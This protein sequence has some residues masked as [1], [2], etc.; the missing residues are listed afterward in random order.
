VGAFVGK[1][2]TSLILVVILG[3]LSHYLLDMIPHKSMG[4]VKGFKE[5]GLKGSDK[6]DLLFKGIEPIMGL[7][8]ALYI[9]FGLNGDKALLMF[10]GGFFAWLPDLLSYF[11]W[12]HDLKKARK[13]LPIPGG[14]FYNRAK[15]PMI[16][17]SL[18]IISIII[19]MVVIL[20]V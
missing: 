6:K 19:I 18:E 3:F 7:I 2:F 17:I 5:K 8:L 16:G 4:G 20:V 1:V 13:F 12:K 10:M 15:K 14:R 11:T 9:A